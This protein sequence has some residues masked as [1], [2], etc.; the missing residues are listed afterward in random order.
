MSA[1]ISLVAMVGVMGLATSAC[2]GGGASSG[3][4]GISDDQEVTVGIS[5]I[6]SGPAATSGQ[7]MTCTVESYLEALR[8]R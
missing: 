4:S 3:D 1:R 8:Y 2:G 7:G 6:L 5:A